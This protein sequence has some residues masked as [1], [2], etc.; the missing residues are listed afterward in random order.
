MASIDQAEPL[1]VGGTPDEAWDAG[2]DWALA[3]M[4]IA[5]AGLERIQRLWRALFGHPSFAMR[6]PGDEALYQRLRAGLI[7]QL[8]HALEDHPGSPARLNA[9]G[10][11]ERA[12]PQTL[13]NRMDMM[14]LDDDLRAHFESGF[15]GL[16]AWLLRLGLTET[17]DRS[18]PCVAALFASHDLYLNCLEPVANEEYEQAAR[19][20]GLLPPASPARQGA[21]HSQQRPDRPNRAQERAA[22]RRTQVRQLLADGHTHKEIAR[23]LKCSERTI[24]GDLAKRQ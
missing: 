7:T 8:E 2:V 3:R 6:Y 21:G 4:A 22:R 23:Q 16:E 1:P 19:R 13:L 20:Y 14:C 11:A 9:L 18:D 12:L 5:L 10:T 17:V 24:R 15:Q